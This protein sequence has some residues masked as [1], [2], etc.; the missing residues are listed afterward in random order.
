MMNRWNRAAYA[1][2]L[3][4]A[5]GLA[6]AACATRSQSGQADSA[7]LPAAAPPVASTSSAASSL[8]P[9]ALSTQQPA[10][11]VSTSAGI[12]PGLSAEA[13]IAEV[14]PS[15]S[16]S[17]INTVTLGANPPGRRIGPWL[18]FSINCDVQENGGCLH[19]LWEA[20]VVQ[21]AV[22]ELMRS[23]QSNLANV[24]TGSTT[25]ASLADGQSVDFGGD[26]GDVAAGQQFTA[27][28]NSDATVEQAI[29]G[30]CAANDV[31]VLSEQILHPLG[32]ALD[33]QL[34]FSS[35]ALNN[36]VTIRQIET[37]IEKKVGTFEAI[38]VEAALADGTTVA[39]AAKDL[40]SGIG[41][42]WADPAYAYLT[43]Y[44]HL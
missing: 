24:I 25:I 31:S 26:Q 44:P 6:L 23:S 2:P 29:S 28:Q 33:L 30:V 37:E 41:R 32:D 43:G 22:A 13:A 40:R 16:Q 35:S 42:Q 36:G 39:R 38:Y 8:P 34:Q 19:S 15:V 21:G 10:A 11:Y 12:G 5:A 9:V 20:D 27:A 7:E 18:Y 4:I 3:L 1:L 17:M 14:L